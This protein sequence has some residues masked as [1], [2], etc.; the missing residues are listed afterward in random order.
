MQMTEDQRKALIQH[1]LEDANVKS[2]MECS[3]L[4]DCQKSGQVSLWLEQLARETLEQRSLL[5]RLLKLFKVSNEN[6]LGKDLDWD[7][8]YGLGWADYE[9]SKSLQP[10]IAEAHT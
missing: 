8:P 9:L 10:Y 7:Q 5:I 2:V 6:I 4:F 3:E 1:Y